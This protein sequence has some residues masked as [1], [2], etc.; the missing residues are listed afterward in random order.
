MLNG[1]LSV[2]CGSFGGV[3]SALAIGATGHTPRYGLTR[4]KED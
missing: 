4:K 2:A 3:L 1:E